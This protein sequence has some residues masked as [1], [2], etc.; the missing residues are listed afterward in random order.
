MKTEKNAKDHDA[1]INKPLDDKILTPFEVMGLQF[2][3][4]IHFKR[5]LEHYKNGSRIYERKNVL[6]EKILK[7]IISLFL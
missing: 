4:K 5:L 6:K 1:K 7:K 3:F 2:G